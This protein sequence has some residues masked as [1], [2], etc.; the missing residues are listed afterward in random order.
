MVGSTLYALTALLTSIGLLMV[1]SGMFGTFIGLSAA[2]EGFS[3]DTIG[4]L[5]T[6][7]YIGLVIGTLRCGPVIN[8][9]GHIRAFAAFASTIAVA[10]LLFPFF[11]EAWVWLGLRAVIGFNIAGL[12]MVAESWLNEQAHGEIRGTVLSIYMMISYL[13]IGSGQLIIGYQP[14]DGVTLFMIAAMLVA[15]ALLPVTL[16]RTE[17]PPPIEAQH[18]PFRRLYEISPVAVIGC[19]C[20]GLA[21]GALFG[22]GAIFAQD[23]GLD[24]VQV[25][26]FMAALIISGLLLQLPVGKLSDRFSRRNVIAWV[27][28]CTTL[29]ALILVGVMGFTSLSGNASHP[30]ATLLGHWLVV[31]LLACV[32]SA[33]LFTLYPLCIA[34]AND[35]LEPAERVPAS[36]GLVLAYSLGAAA[37][38]LIAALGMQRV[39][40]IGLFLFTA[41]SMLILALFVYYR[42][43]RRS[44]VEVVP[45]EPFIALPHATTTPMSTELDPRLYGEQLTLDLQFSDASP[46]D[47][48]FQNRDSH[49]REAVQEKSL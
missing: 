14:L 3:K 1:G 33:L 8:R 35:Y 36:G 49:L 12:Y 31:P 37:G 11:T 7:N 44:W 26:H 42:S 9:V 43:T 21:T 41:A 27:A 32:C 47:D 2:A 39:G 20:T 40:P 24:L 22:M 25:S 17:H 23:I 10:I 29:S 48:E 30:L 34:Y 38:P 28:A 45:K 16:T 19:I 13:G 46:W 6:A 5:T 18:F 15:F 4:L